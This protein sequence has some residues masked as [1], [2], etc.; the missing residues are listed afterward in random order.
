MFFVG[1][2]EL[3][4]IKKMKSFLIILILS[5][6]IGCSLN[7]N[8]TVYVEHL[9]SRLDGDRFIDSLKSVGV[10]TIIGYYDGC[11]GCILGLEKPYYVFWD[12]GK[13][14][15]VTK[16][17]KYSRYNH[18]AGYTPP[19]KYLSENLD[20]IENGR[21]QKPRYELN[22][23]PYDVIRIYL[24]DKEIKYEITADEK[25]TNEASQ[26]VILIDKIRSKLLDILPGE[27]KGLNYKSEKRRKKST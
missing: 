14:W 17:T 26:K 18:I 27:W 6:L 11:S 22:H 25:G 21:I 3:G 5:F 19:I 20:I 16:F 8:S 1:G 10:D 23:Y 15:Y 9:D 13:K 7:R 4:T 24:S 12:A 2:R